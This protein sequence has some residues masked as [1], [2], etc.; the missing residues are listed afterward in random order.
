MGA[1]RA[2][3]LRLHGFLAAWG[4]APGDVALAFGASHAGVECVVA[5]AE[6]AEQVRENSAAMARPL[7]PGLVEALGRIAVASPIEVLDPTRWPAEV[8]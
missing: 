6:T 5:G 1:A 3:V 2:T 7:P 8:P 4:V